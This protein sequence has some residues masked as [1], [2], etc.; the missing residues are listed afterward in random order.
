MTVEKV[1]TPTEINK[2]KEDIETRAK[3]VNYQYPVVISNADGKTGRPVV[4]SYELTEVKTSAM[5]HHFGKGQPDEFIFKGI[6]GT[7][8]WF[9]PATKE[10]KKIVLPKMPKLDVVDLYNFAADMTKFQEALRKLTVLQTMTDPR[11]ASTGLPTVGVILADKI[12]G[13]PG[14]SST[15]ESLLRE[16]FVRFGSPSTTINNYLREHETSRAVVELKDKYWSALSTQYEIACREL[17]KSVKNNVVVDSIN[18]QSNGI[19]PVVV[20]DAH[21]AVSEVTDGNKFGL[22]N[23]QTSALGNMFDSGAINR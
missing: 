12:I 20:N 18:L 7:Y 6:L 8:E 15:V 2:L 17:A 23:T 22:K 14:L 19:N 4:S 13:E 1:W 3:K 9:D 10:T 11:V 5:E 21:I 16:S